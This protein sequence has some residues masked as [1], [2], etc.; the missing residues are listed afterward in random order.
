MDNQPIK[1]RYKTWYWGKYILNGQYL[2][3]NRITLKDRDFE[4]Y[5]EEKHGW[6]NSEEFKKQREISNDKTI[7]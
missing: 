6:H 1:I 3:G 2:D 4:I 7:Y 5:D